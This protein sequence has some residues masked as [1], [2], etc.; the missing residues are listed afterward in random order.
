MSRAVADE[1]RIDS[2][3]DDGVAWIT[4]DRPTR[5]NAF[6]GSMRDDLHAALGDAGARPDVRAVVITGAGRAFCAG[7]DVATM[8]G[9][10]ERGDER[11][12]GGFVD[13]GM[14][15]VR[16]IRALPCPVIAAVNGVAAGAGASL[17]AACDL[18]IAARGASIGFTFNR[19]G[20][21][22]DWGAT[23][24]L[25]RLVG[26]G[27]A[28]ELVATARM[29]G[30]AEAERIGLFDRVVD[31]DA[32]ADAV[33]ALARELAAGP[34]GALAAAKRSLARTFESTLEE[35]LELE[36]RAQLECFAGDEVREGVRA[37]REKRPADY[38]AR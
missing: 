2:R 33:A 14:R 26:A 4:I 5:L 13:A 28:L 10:L 31:D 19:I 21:H 25:P 38:S 34:P 15:V 36:R 23:Y 24:F 6:V 17:A 1:G 32:F 20:L 11:T 30:S 16:Q 22:P 3:V 7:A 18:R 37:F 35:M 29:V 12:F 8:A 27:R 9:L